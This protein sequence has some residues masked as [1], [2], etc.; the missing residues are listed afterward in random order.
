[1]RRRARQGFS[2]HLVVLF[3]EALPCLGQGLLPPLSLQGMARMLDKCQDARDHDIVLRLHGWLCESGVEAQTTLGNHLVSVLVE[4]GSFCYAQRVFDRLTVRTESSWC[5]LITGLTSCGKARHA[6]TLFYKTWNF[7]CM[8]P[9]GH[10][11]V[12]LLQ[13]CASLRD[14]ES[15]LQIHA[16]FLNTDMLEG[17]PFVGSA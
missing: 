10:T 2:H 11:A 1:M 9:N 5:S 17:D 4:A 12:A 8:R 3:Q 7:D 6:L 13:A 14:L 15:G 16:E